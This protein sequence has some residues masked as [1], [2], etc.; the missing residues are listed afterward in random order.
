MTPDLNIV[1][2]E[3]S[4]GKLPQNKYGFR[5]FIVDQQKMA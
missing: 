5:L 3:H 4:L 2:P 1:E